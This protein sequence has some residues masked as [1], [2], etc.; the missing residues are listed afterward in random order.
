VNAP[1]LRIHLFALAWAQLWSRPLATVLNWV[2]L[3]LGVTALSLV[4]L[5]DS[6]VEQALQRD[7][8]G[9]DLVVGAK[10]SPLQLILAGVYHLD[11][12]TG[13][14]P[15]AAVAQL[16]AHPLVETVIPLSLGDSLSGFRI[17]GTEPAYLDHYGLKPAQGRLWAAPLEAVLGADVAAVTG[18]KIDQRFVGSHGLGG[19]GDE[20]AEAPYTVVG[21]LPRSGTVLDRLVL[22]GLESVWA[23]HE[24]AHG[25]ATLDAE[26][27]AALADA[28]A[29][30]REV[31]LLLLRYR[32]PLAAVTLPRA[33]N[34]G[35]AWQAASP[36]VEMSR[37]G[38]L[39][40]VGAELMQGFGAALLA[41]AGLSVFVGL[42]HAVRE[43]LPDLAML[44]M[45]GARPHQVALLV[46]IE[47]LWLALLGLALG[48][49]LAQA[50]TAGLGHWLAL[51]RSVAVS[52]W[53]W[54]VE[55]ALVP[56]GT[57]VVTLLAAALPAR[58]AYRLDVTTLLQA[59]R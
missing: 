17:V 44:R 46:L 26:D 27:R 6:Q 1:P 39:I 29:E 36:A 5:I 56:A 52:G 59:P 4:I 14:I 51:Q 12:P 42:W 8:Q 47:A 41:V 11:V 45:L 15:L 32:T 10:G 19:G 40:G 50:L 16:R 13:N 21:V 43:R 24:A 54:P 34:S 20:H 53:V 35:T 2:L 9:I 38:R 3:A 55:L 22:T 33:I 57:L 25:G 58:S 30:D 48:L 31:T 28:L 49:L 18:L 23:V 7:V 37:L